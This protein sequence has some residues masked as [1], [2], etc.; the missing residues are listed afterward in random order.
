MMNFR[1]VGVYGPVVNCAKC[2]TSFSPRRKDQRFCSKPC[3]KAATRNA[4]R[5][6]RELEFSVTARRTHEVR[7]GRIK[8]LSHGLY[9]TPPA[10]RS[11]YLQRLIAEGRG[12]A[13]LRRL[14]TVRDLLRSWGRDE[15]TGRLHIVHIL[16]HFCQEVYG[17]RSF[18]VFNPATK[19]PSADILAFPA[20]YF[21]PDAPPVYED[22][23]LKTRPGH[24]G[25]RKS[26]S[27][28]IKGSDNTVYRREHNGGLAVA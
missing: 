1:N 21:G 24:W 12:N 16:D 2:A 6:T 27:T 26:P 22:G 9:E 10:Y 15:G 8:G 20:A 11:D 18:Q 7:K 13:E 14:V 3:A 5:G 23:R 25:N 19:L 4:S 28:I 17:M